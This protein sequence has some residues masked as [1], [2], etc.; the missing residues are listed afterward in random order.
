MEELLWHRGLQRGKVRIPR[1]VDRAKA[2]PNLFNASNSYHMVCGKSLS[3]D[4]KEWNQKREG[5]LKGSETQAHP[6]I[7]HS[8]SQIYIDRE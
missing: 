8:F 2:Y 4:I 5:Y 7:D 6:Y 3:Q 1:K